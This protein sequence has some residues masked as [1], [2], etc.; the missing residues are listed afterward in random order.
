M[1]VFYS[2]KVVLAEI[3]GKH[4]FYVKFIVFGSKMNTFSHFLGSGGTPGGHVSKRCANHLQK[5]P[6]SSIFGLPFGGHF[7]V[8]WHLKIHCFSGG[9]FFTLFLI[10]VSP[11]P[12]K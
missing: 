11:G 2:I 8:F 3:S 10:L 1:G 4:L 5:P 9:D 6:K 7:G 12:P